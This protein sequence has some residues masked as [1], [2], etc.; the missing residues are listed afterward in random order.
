[1]ETLEGLRKRIGTTTDL[2]SIV[3]TMKSLSAASIRHYEHAVVSL[4]QYS[5]TVRMGLQIVLQASPSWKPAGQAHGPVGVI[6][7]GSDHGL[8]GQFN[9]Q[10]ARFAQSALSTFSGVK[11]LAVGMRAAA[12]LEADGVPLEESLALP[13]TVD[14]L[15]STVHALLLRIERL[16][17][18]GEAARLFVIHNSRHDGEAASPRRVQLLPLDPAWLGRLAARRWQG[19]TL[20]VFRMD[21]AALFAALVRQHLF[22]TLYRAVAESLMSEHASRLAAMQT[23]EKN[24][25]EHLAEMTAAF[26]HRRQETITSELL[27][28]IAGFE[29]TAPRSAKRGA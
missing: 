15:T 11:W 5:E 29:A 1:M 26:Q 2:Q 8:C 21:P 24:I 13:A 6:V 25:E 14:G 4:R 23:A 19:P 16:Q 9:E 27:D 10:V 28:I 7:V 20:P 18:E 17:R 12:R 22:V 3:R